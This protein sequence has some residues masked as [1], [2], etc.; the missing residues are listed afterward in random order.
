MSLITIEAQSFGPGSLVGIKVVEYV[1]PTHVSSE[2]GEHLK[3]P[4]TVIQS[5]NPDSV[6]EYRCVVNRQM[7]VGEA[8]VSADEAGVGEADVSV[9]E[10]DEDIVSVREAD[11]SRGG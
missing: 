5:I 10:A 9:G 4:T 11:V 7:S 2:E 6:S 1:P 3:R 8:N